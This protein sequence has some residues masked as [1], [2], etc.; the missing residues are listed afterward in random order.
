MALF[1]PSC[2]SRESPSASLS[3]GKAKPWGLKGGSSEHGGGGEKGGG[4][5]GLSRLRLCLGCALSLIRYLWRKKVP[6]RE[7]PA[8]QS[9]ELPGRRLRDGRG[10]R[11]HDG[12]AGR[13][14]G[15]KRVF[16]FFLFATTKK[17]HGGGRGGK[18]V[19]A[20]R[21][22]SEKLVAVWSVNTSPSAPREKGGCAR[23]TRGAAGRRRGG[24]APGPPRA[25][26]ARPKPRGLQGSAGH[27]SQ[28]RT[29]PRV[30]PGSSM[31]A[32]PSEGRRDHPRLGDGTGRGGGGMKQP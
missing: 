20:G 24:G 17:K 25:P 9:G 6:R 5:A 3:P 32:V 4:E 14:A 19:G 22:R 2:L 30:H 7:P 29:S 27:R 8:S 1:L 13:R 21:E 28:S 15:T 26:A 12:R 18:A 11:G 16:F 31:T 23:Q 10:L